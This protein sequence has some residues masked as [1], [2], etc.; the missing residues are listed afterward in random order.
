MSVLGTV[1]GIG[2]TMALFIASLALPEGAKLEQGK[3]AIL[4]ASGLAIA[5]GLVIGRIALRPA[6]EGEPIPSAAEAETSD[7]D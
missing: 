7:E 6:A 3:T 1:A 5:L 2:F 4:L